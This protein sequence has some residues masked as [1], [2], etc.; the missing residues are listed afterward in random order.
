M[1][2]CDGIYTGE[3]TKAQLV[4][5]FEYRAGIHQSYITLLEEQPNGG[6]DAYGSKEWHMWAIGGYEWGIFYLQGGIEPM[7][8]KP[9]WQSKTIWVN[10]LMAL[11][12]IL[13][14]TIGEDLLNAETQAAIVI[15]V[16]LILRLITGKPLSK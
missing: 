2:V 15:V 6:W 7:Q 4:D 1:N 5:Q 8:A 16:N 13:N 10:V 3:L 11:G 14:M 12:V 9:F